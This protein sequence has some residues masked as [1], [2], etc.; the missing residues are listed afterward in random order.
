M[1]LGGPS[2]NVVPPLTSNKYYNDDVLLVWNLEDQDQSMYI[3]QIWINMKF[4]KASYP[5]N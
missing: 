4:E 2:H 1:A 5:S 3:M